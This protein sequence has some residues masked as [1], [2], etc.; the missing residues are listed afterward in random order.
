MIKNVFIN[1]TTN[2]INYNTSNLIPTYNINT[3]NNNT[4]NKI[5]NI[6]DPDSIIDPSSSEYKRILKRANKYKTERER[7]EAL[8]KV[9]LI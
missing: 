2:N 3:T 9:I 5:T 4:T 7:K 1:N 6:I 8:K